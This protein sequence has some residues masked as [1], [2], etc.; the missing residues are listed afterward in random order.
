VRVDLFNTCGERA[1]SVAKA[2]ASGVGE[3]DCD[4]VGIAAGI[5]VARISTDGRELARLKVAVIH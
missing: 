4:C 3:L 5:Y 2:C 1:A